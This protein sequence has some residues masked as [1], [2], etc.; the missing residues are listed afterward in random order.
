MPF[1][2]PD[3]IL[4]YMDGTVFISDGGGRGQAQSL[5]KVT[6]EGGAPT[7]FVAPETVGTPNM[8]NPYG[9]AISPPT[10]TGHNVNPGDLIVADN[11]FAREIH[12]AV[13]AI[14]PSTGA[15]RPI[16]KGSVFVDGPLSV[17]F[18]PDAGRL[19]CT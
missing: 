7:P 11:G 14:N 12:K 9:M 1:V 13:W 19:T 15:A 6:T 4:L 3:D 8:F 5:F 18:G 10:F 2:G 16:A 17:G